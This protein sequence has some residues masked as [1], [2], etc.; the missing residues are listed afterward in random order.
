LTYNIIDPEKRIVSRRN[1][2]TVILL[3][4]RLCFEV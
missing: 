3:K 2:C 4:L 1:E